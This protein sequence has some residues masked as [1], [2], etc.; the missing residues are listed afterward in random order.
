MVQSHELD[1]AVGDVLQLGDKTVTVIDIDQGEVTFRIDDGESH[2]DD[3][4]IGHSE[5]GN[6]PIPR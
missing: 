4:T 3:R 5:N 2:D 6:G 1:L